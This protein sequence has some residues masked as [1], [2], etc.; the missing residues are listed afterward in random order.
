MKMRTWET[1]LWNLLF[2]IHL[3]HV[4]YFG[5]AWMS[6]AQLYNIGT[7]FMLNCACSIHWPTYFHRSVILF[8]RCLNKVFIPGRILCMLLICVSMYGV[9]C[10]LLWFNFEKGKCGD[11][12]ILR[13]KNRPCVHSLVWNC[14]RDLS[15]FLHGICKSGSTKS[16]WS[17]LTQGL[18]SDYIPFPEPSSEWHWQWM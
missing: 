16:W 4:R 17:H 7:L 15:R 14:W 11:T 13:K 9:L 8:W 12:V 5:S 3:A 10:L 1:S 2:S 6:I 18:W